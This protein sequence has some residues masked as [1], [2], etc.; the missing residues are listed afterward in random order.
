M[1][2]PIKEGLDYLPLDVDFFENPK[3]ETIAE[4]YGCAGECII[5]R[6]FCKIYDN[7]AYI[8][9]N[10]LLIKPLAKHTGTSAEIVN[11]VIKSAIEYEIFDKGKFEQYG[12]LTSKG[13]QERYL[14]AKKRSKG[15]DIPEEFLLSE[16]DAVFTQNELMQQKPA[17][18][19]GYC[20]INSVSEAVIATLTPI[21]SELLQTQNE[22]M[23]QKPSLSGSYCNIN[24]GSEVVIANSKKEKEE[25]ER[26]ERTKEKKEEKEK[27]N[28]AADAALMRASA[29]EAAAAAEQ[30]LDTQTVAPDVQQ[31]LDAIGK[32][33]NIIPLPAHL[34]ALEA[35]ISD[36]NRPGVVNGVDV[37]RDGLAK[38]DTAEAINERRVTL[39]MTQFL[40]PKY[41]MRLLG[42]DYDKV[43]KSKRKSGA[44]QDAGVSFEDMDY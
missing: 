30:N 1:A 7:G 9:C 3:I 38:M 21:K 15:S 22:L 8:K 13:I 43:Y 29:R 27:E 20:N 4:D 2:R 44:W 23:Q 32:R 31:L 25:E 42:G 6:L 18:N 36:C 34:T 40:N 37:V 39:T 41:F 26:K 28:K 5:L 35:L 14:F 16:T 24:S 11:N 12:V 10:D 33:F 19:E 17:L